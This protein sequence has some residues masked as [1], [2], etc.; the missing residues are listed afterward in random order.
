[1]NTKVEIKRLI[2]KFY[3]GE[4]SKA[5]EEIIINYFLTTDIDNDL[6]EE[7]ELFLGMQ[8]L[9]QDDIASPSELK[10]ELEVIIDQVSDLQETNQIFKLK[11]TKRHWQI[12]IAATV[13]LLMGVVLTL[14]P[15]RIQKPKDS[16]TD[17]Q[18]AYTEMSKALELMS[19]TMNKCINKSV[20]KYQTIDKKTETIIKQSI[21][22]FNNKNI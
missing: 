10:A 8:T 6:E 12:G 13:A 19:T 22:K 21:N 4:T 16:F 2:D 15:N 3:E 20:N 1:M 9:K 11:S 5:E 18:L 7:M 14:G 17:P